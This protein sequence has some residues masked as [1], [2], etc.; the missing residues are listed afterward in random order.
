[1]EET[2]GYTS[3]AGLDEG[4]VM[5]FTA[6]DGTY[7]TLRPASKGDA[8][9]II[10]KAEEIVR[11]GRYIQ[12]EKVRS[13]EDEQAFIEEVIQ[14]GNMYAVIDI[15]GNIFGIARI[16]RGELEMKRHTGVFRTWLSEGAQGKGIGKKIMEYTLEWSRRNHLHKIWLTVFSRNE[17]AYLIAD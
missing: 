5:S 16:I 1:V 4:I 14:E 17:V 3:K 9:D 7:V 10:T 11:E 2:K 8:D 6:K 15:E 13:L 12:K